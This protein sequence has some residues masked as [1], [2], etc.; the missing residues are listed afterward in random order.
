MAY[1]HHHDKRPIGEVIAASNRAIGQS[2]R[3]DWTRA[4]AVAVIGEALHDLITET[5]SYNRR[6][7]SPKKIAE[8]KLDAAQFIAGPNL[9]AWAQ[10]TSLTAD[11]WREV[12][13]GIV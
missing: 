1:S 5:R 13:R 9:D 2:E 11:Q 10:F 4:L 7:G 12:A 8:R 3:I 6:P